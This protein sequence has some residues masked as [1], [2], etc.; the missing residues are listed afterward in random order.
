MKEWELHKAFGKHLEK[1]K[2]LPLEN[3][4]QAIHVDAI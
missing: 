2:I 1:E 3:S 4:G